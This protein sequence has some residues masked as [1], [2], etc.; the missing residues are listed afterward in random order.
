VRARDKR[1]ADGRAAEQ[2]DELA[3]S[4]LLPAQERAPVTTGPRS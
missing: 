2:R 3:S 4:C 1:P